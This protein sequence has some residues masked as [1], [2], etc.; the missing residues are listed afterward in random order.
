M[1]NGL[2]EVTFS[3]NSFSLTFFAFEFWLCSQ[4]LLLLCLQMGHKVTRILVGGR[5]ILRIFHW[6]RVHCL[7]PKAP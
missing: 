4:T 5:G 6:A 7:E 3:F 1:N 2:E